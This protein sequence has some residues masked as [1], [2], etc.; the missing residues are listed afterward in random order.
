MTQSNLTMH[1]A[2]PPVAFRP[3][4]G[5]SAQGSR[6]RRSTLT[7]SRSRPPRVSVIIPHYNDLENLKRCMNL[8]GE[9][10]LPPD[11][12]E[13]IVADNNSRCGID[14]VKR[15]CGNRARC[16]SADPRCRSGAQR[17][18]RRVARHDT[19]VH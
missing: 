10:T 13:V 18:G 7:T 2:S 15:A 4:D 9:E 1:N 19:R 3:T 5:Q 8:L 14:E 12:F 16:P 11:D 6:R 17:G